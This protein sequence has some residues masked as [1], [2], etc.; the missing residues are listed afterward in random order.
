MPQIGDTIREKELKPTSSYR[1]I[2]IWAACS[3][4]GRERWV[5]LK[6]KQPEYNRCDSLECRQT[7]LKGTHHAN[8]IGRTLDKSGYVLIWVDIED[9]FAPMRKSHGYVY[10]HRLVMARHLGRNLQGWELVHHKDGDKGNNVLA[11]LKMTTKG[12]HIVEHNKGY[13]DGYRQGYED[14]KAKAIADKL[15]LI[16]RCSGRIKSS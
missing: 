10:E 2:F 8:R 5:R 7:F 1:R 16:R 3:L 4:C 15:G 6:K 14:G 11:N 12:S 9:F 13:K